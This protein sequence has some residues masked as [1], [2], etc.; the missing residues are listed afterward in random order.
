MLDELTF[1]D[2]LNL[3]NCAMQR[4]KMHTVDADRFHGE[5]TTAR[6]WTKYKCYITKTVSFVESD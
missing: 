4:A 6:H 2:R 1:F 5:Y 3:A